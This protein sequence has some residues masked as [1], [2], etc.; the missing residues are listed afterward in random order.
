MKTAKTIHP[1]FLPLSV[2]NKWYSNQLERYDEILAFNLESISLLQSFQNSK[3]YALKKEASVLLTERLKKEVV[4]LT[5]VDP[6]LI[7]WEIQDR[8]G[9]KFPYSLNNKQFAMKG[10]HE[11]LVEALVYFLNSLNAKSDIHLT[12]LASSQKSKFIIEGL[13]NL[14]NREDELNLLN[15]VM[16]LMN[17]SLIIGYKAVILTLPSEDK[18]A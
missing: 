10:D 7:I 1:A 15:E 4:S 18:F 16:E 2:N 14:E 6:R 17:G 9:L 11:L 12:Y 8:S 13:Q 3:A 5:E